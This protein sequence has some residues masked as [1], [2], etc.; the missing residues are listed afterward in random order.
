MKTTARPID[1]GDGQGAMEVISYELGSSFMAN[2]DLEAYKKRSWIHN[3]D[4]R[5]PLGETI[6]HTHDDEV[7][8][9]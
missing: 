7:V 2:T 6:L 8:V 1:G 5:V 3:A 9:F 4:T